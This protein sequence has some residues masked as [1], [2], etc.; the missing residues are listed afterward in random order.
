MKPKLSKNKTLIL[1][2]AMGTQ[3]IKKGLDL[4]LPL[5]SADINESKSD[6]VYQIHSDYSESLSDI[7]TTNTF[8]TT[9][10]SYQ[11]AGHSPKDALM[12]SKNSFDCAIRE[13]VRAKK[14]NQILAGSIAPIEEC[15]SPELFPGINQSDAS[16][17]VLIE[18]FMCTEIDVLLFETMGN[19]T[20]IKN[21]LKHIEAWNRSVW[22]S[23]ILKDE[24]HLLDGSILKNVISIINESPIE[25]LLFNCNTIELTIKAIRLIKENWNK[26]WGVYPN[27]GLTNPEV[28]GKMNKIVSDKDWKNKI[29]KNI[30][31]KT[32]NNWSMLWL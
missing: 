32:S 21:V 18:W 2:G 11:K 25:V 17:K 13:A 20:E 1:D 8:R 9:P 3:L 29:K 24:T 10:Y 19:I 23:L 31:T 12:F 27:L 15:Y 28:D 14:S 30:S 5:W 4:S 7:L 16:I 26:F 22:M 6:I